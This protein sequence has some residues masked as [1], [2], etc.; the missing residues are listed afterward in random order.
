MG[1]LYLYDKKFVFFWHENKY[2]LTKDGVEYIVKAHYTKVSASLVRA[3]QIK[4]LVNSSKGCMLMVVRE[5][6]AETDDAF[7]GC[8]PNHKKELFGII[9]YYDGLFQEPSGFRPKLEIQHE[10]H[11]QRDAPLPNI[12]MYRMLTIEMEEIK[13]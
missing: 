4:R 13:K 2:H 7:E 8:D 6:E 12:G 5:K 10:I 11:L 9:F 1:S 3:G